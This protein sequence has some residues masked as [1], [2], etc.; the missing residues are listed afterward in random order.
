MRLFA[1]ILALGCGLPAAAQTEV[2]LEN[3]PST[4][5]FHKPF[6][7]NQKDM[8]PSAMQTIT[9]NS[10][11]YVVKGVAMGEDEAQLLLK[12]KNAVVCTLFANMLTV[13]DSIAQDLPV[14]VLDGAIP[15]AALTSSNSF[16][17]E[18]IGSAGSH[19]T[20]TLSVTLTLD[21][22]SAQYK[23]Q[24]ITDLAVTRTLV[25]SVEQA[26]DDLTL[27]SA[28][29]N[30]CFGPDVELIPGQSVL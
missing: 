6:V 16:K 23:N 30:D 22:N 3:R 29:L 25:G 4:L 9:S 14:V 2:A 7:I 21:R 11:V 19:S 18:N 27:T 15:L 10:K 28:Q 17:I 1:L 12:Q 8:G 20:G 13:A 26:E 24:F 5:V